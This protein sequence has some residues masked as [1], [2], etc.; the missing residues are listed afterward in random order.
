MSRKL[1]SALC[2]S[3]ALVSSAAL[4]A[5]KAAIAQVAIDVA[6]P[7]APP[8]LP[9]YD[10]PPLPADGYV[11]EPGYWAWDP[12]ANDYYWVPGVWVQPPEAGLL[13]TPG[14]WGW[15]GSAYSYNAGYWG[16]TVGYYGGI[17]YGYGYDGEGYVGGRWDHGAFFYN[18]AANNIGNVHVVNVYN[19]P[20]VKHAEA[21]RTSFNGGAG[22]ASGKPT[23]AQIAAAKQAHVPATAAQIQHQQAARSIRDAHFSANKGRPAVTAVSKPGELKGSGETPTNV[24]KSQQAPPKANEQKAEPAGAIPSI[25]RADAHKP[26]QAK[27]TIARSRTAPPMNRHAPPHAMQTVR[28]ATPHLAPA[29]RRQASPRPAPMVHHAPPRS[30]PA[31]SRG[32]AHHA[33]PHARAPARR[34]DRK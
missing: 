34:P 28:H 32:P 17:D 9:D 19:T 24:T 1:L 5:P 14:Y 15:N 16:P 27:P 11:W 2:V 33:A 20:V 3:V 4:I 31:R 13:W 10:Q 7:I 26:T 23:E 29:G 21:R 25:S 8:D 18:R 22:G 6:V 12:E 30:A